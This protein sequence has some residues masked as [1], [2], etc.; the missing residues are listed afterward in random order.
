MYAE[1]VTT[2]GLSKAEG[3][4]GGRAGCLVGQVAWSG[5]SDE[6]R[7]TKKANEVSAC[8]S[9]VRANNS[10]RGIS[11]R[12]SASVLAL[13]CIWLLTAVSR[14]ASAPLQNDELDCA[15]VGP[16]VLHHL[17]VAVAGCC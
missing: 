17:A 7:N 12:T 4:G 15:E 5:S 6:C 10:R 9:T 2:R 11:D 14:C 16:F 13:A 8:S 3:G 1:D